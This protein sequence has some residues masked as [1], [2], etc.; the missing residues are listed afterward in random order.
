MNKFSRITISLLMGSLAIS[1]LNAESLL[2]FN[3]VD[4]NKTANYTIASDIK[5]SKAEGVNLTFKPKVNGTK[6]STFELQFTNGGYEDIPKILMCSQNQPVGLMYSQGDDYS[7]TDHIMP[8]PRFQFNSDVNESLIV[9]KSNI[10]FHEGED[11]CSA[12]NPAVVSNSAACLPISVKIDEGKTTTN[13][14]F[15]DYNTNVATIGSTKKMVSIACETP[16]CTIDATKGSKLFTTS[17]TPSGINLSLNNTKAANRDA[18]D[19]SNCPECEEKAAAPCTVKISVRTI[20]TDTNLTSFTL[21]TAFKD[22]K[23]AASSIAL[24]ST[25]VNGVAY[26]HGSTTEFNFDTPVSIGKDQNITIVYTPNKT[27]ILTAGNLEGSVTTMDTVNADG[28]HDSDVTTKSFNDG[29]VTTFEVAGKTK[30]TVPYMNSKTSNMVRISNTQDTVREL[31]AAITDTNGKKCNVNYSNL[32]ANS[33]TM[34]FAKTK[35]GRVA[36]SAY[37]NLIPEGECSNLTSTEYSVVFTTSGSVDVVSY[38]TMSNGSQRYVDV[39]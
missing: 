15:K 19:F 11:N 13:I 38:M 27:S 26:T 21:N 25:K 6:G 12:P 37:R 30:F 28:A 1:T 33:A 18:D 3:G 17:V 32:A 7:D 23:G 24:A 35:A 20:S 34:L 16:V 36:D 2:V 22:E 9:A 10:T 5:S 4:T 8:N 29:V 31:S 14:D 39:Y